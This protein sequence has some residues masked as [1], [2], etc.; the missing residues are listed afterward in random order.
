MEYFDKSADPFHAVQSSIDML[1]KAGFEQLEDVEPYA[2]KLKPGGKY[3]YH[4]NKSTLVAYVYSFEM[5]K[6]FSL[7]TDISNMIFLRIDLP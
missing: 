6:S 2:G 4:R 5:E 3:F 1:I 7:A